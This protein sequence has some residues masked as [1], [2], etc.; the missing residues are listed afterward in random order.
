MRANEVVQWLKVQSHTENMGLI[1]Y[2]K[3]RAPTP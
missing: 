1:T 3:R 2:D